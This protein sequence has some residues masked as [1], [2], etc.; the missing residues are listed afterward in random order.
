M[1]SYDEFKTMIIEKIN[2]IDKSYKDMEGVYE[3]T[4][5]EMKLKDFLSDIWG[6]R[7]EDET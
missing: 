2:V 5:R 1:Q 4:E 7:F 3:P 6:V